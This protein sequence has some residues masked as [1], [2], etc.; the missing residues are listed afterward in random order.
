[1]DDAIELAE[2]DYARQEELLKERLRVMY[3]RSTTV[4]EIEELLKSKSL[5]ELF[6]RIRLMKQVA[7]FDQSL[8]RSIEDKSLKLKH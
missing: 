4:W 1:M 3:K 8:L 2:Q 6:L 5:N 7:E